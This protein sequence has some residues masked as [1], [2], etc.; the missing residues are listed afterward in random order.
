M[1]ALKVFTEDVPS[2]KYYTRRC[3]Q[4]SQV[5]TVSQTPHNIGQAKLPNTHFR[6][7]NYQNPL[8]LFRADSCA[9]FVLTLLLEMIQ[10]SD[11]MA[12]AFWTDLRDAGLLHLACILSA[13]SIIDFLLSRKPS[14]LLTKV[15]HALPVWV[16]R[17]CI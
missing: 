2:H 4:P 6:C 3:C 10:C 17:T 15:S 1:S 12:P 16:L 9:F 11:Y 13:H 5:S 14:I 8:D 7:A